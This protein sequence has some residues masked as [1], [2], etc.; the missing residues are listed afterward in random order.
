M[1]SSVQYRTGVWT[2][3]AGRLQ[4]VRDGRSPV[5]G[6]RRGPPC[7]KA[8]A[9]DNFG[10]PAGPEQIARVSKP[11]HI[12]GT[13]RA[14]PCNGAREDAFREPSSCGVRPRFATR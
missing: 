7:A 4:Q 12:K 6:S 10:L 9:A 2:T 11:G 14:D 3:K 5:I 8:K 13:N 1:R